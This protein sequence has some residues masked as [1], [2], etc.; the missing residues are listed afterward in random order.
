MDL[1][2]QADAAIDN[3]T[4]VQCDP[5]V[6]PPGATG[7][8][9]H[10]GAFLWVW[11]AGEDPA[12]SH[13]ATGRWVLLP[14]GCQVILTC[15]PPQAQGCSHVSPWPRAHILPPDIC[16]PQEHG[17]NPGSVAGGS[18]YAG[19]GK[20]TFGVPV[21]FRGSLSTPPSPWSPLSGQSCPATSRQA[22]AAGT[23]IR[24]A[25]S[26]GSTAQGRGRAL[27]TPLVLVRGQLLSWRPGQLGGPCSPLSPGWDVPC[28]P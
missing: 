26:S 27:T 12:Q 14:G 25:T 24:P 13:Q 3:V 5:N 17:A 8:S 16:H 18:S 21:C 22:C 7:M 20:G 1:Q 9:E 6:V 23:R 11:W 2:D 15:P 19:Q 4:F 28:T 10:A